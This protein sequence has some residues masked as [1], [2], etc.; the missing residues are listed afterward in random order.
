MGGKTPEL[1]RPGVLSG[2]AAVKHDL[3]VH[4]VAE[5]E[6]SP[7]ADAR[8]VHSPQSDGSSEE[9]FDAVA[10]DPAVHAIGGPQSLLSVTAAS[11]Q[12][13]NA[14]VGVGASSPQSPV[15]GDDVDAAAL[16]VC[17]ARA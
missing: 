11:A 7:A 3:P 13:L 10:F 8:R 4:A 16:Q 9:F 14:G 1:P 2:V 17:Y 15:P 5:S 12:G 6:A